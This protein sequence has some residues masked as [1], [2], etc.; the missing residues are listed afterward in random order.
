MIYTPSPAA[1]FILLNQL[2]NLINF[3]ILSWLVFDISGDNFSKIVKILNDSA[4][5][6]ENFSQQGADALIIQSIA[7]RMTKYM[8]ETSNLIQKSVAALGQ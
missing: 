5:W 4:F 2:I 7:V 1:S 6:V 3:I 8:P